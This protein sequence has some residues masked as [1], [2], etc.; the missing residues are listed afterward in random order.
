[1]MGGASHI[2]RLLRE[3]YEIESAFS[4]E[5]AYQQL[6]TSSR[7]NPAEI[8]LPMFCE[9]LEDLT[10][11]RLLCVSLNSNGSAVYQVLRKP[12]TT[13]RSKPTSVAS[14]IEM[15]KAGTADGPAPVSQI[16][17][18]GKIEPAKVVRNVLNILLAQGIVKQSSDSPMKFQWNAAQEDAL[19]RGQETT[20]EFH[21]LVAEI[22]A[23]DREI[24]G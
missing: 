12:R 10:E 14:V 6:V 16:L 7:M 8:P 23:L 24:G 5:S 4:A 11:Q 20:A 1:M 15:I 3:T 19:M 18:S 21:R 2:C 17:G 22:L 9:Y 13:G